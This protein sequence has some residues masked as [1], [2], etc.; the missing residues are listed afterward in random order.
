[1]ST[2]L[3]IVWI[4]LLGAAL[5]TFPYRMHH[6]QRQSAPAT[7]NAHATSLDHNA[8]VGTH[9]ETSRVHR[10]WSDRLKMWR[11]AHETTIWD[12]RRQVTGRGSSAETSQKAAERRW[13]RRANS[14]M[15]E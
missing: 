15:I 8:F 14:K 12:S 4:I 1:M 11:R 13:V 5:P 9:V 3:I 2:I 7:R 10:T 6:T